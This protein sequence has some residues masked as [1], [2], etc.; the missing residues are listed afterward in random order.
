[1]SRTRSQRLA[2]GHPRPQIENSNLWR[3]V[4]H[5]DIPPPLI[6]IDTFCSY[7][8][9]A[10]T[11]VPAEKYGH[12][13]MICRQKYGYTRRHNTVKDTLAQVAFR[14]CQM[15]V[16]HEPHNLVRTP[17]YRPDLFAPST[18]TAYDI[19]VLSA[20]ASANVAASAKA[21]RAP[22]LRRAAEKHKRYDARLAVIGPGLKLLTSAS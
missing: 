17:S 9:D 1:M 5:N 20:Y 16:I 19:T 8:A 4:E 10:G 3:T 22:I 6:P 21:S 13:A 12:H 18:H 14:R 2:T 11:P 7:C 15:T